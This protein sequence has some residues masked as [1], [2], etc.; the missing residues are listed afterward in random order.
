[1]CDLTKTKCGM[2][3]CDIDR[4]MEEAVRET[5]RD[6]NT[7]GML[8]ISLAGALVE[9]VTQACQPGAYRNGFVMGKKHHTFPAANIVST[10]SFWLE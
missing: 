6:C 5:E 8:M 9:D 1:M 7:H 2:R 10:V 3:K 4:W